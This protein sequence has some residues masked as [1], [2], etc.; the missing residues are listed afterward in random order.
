MVRNGREEREKVTERERG[1]AIALE[2][3]AESQRDT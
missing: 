1:P 3:E 2:I